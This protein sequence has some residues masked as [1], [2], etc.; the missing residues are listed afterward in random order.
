MRVWARLLLA[1]YLAVLVWL[2]LFKLSLDWGA[3]LREY[4]IR[5]LNLVP[6][7]HASW[8]IRSETVANVLAFVP[9]G[10]LTQVTLKRGSLWWKLLG[11]FLVSV[12]F[13]TT[14]YV[15]A[16][17]V[18]DITDVLTNTMG[19]LLGLLLYR[20]TRRVLP[21]RS[22]DIGVTIGGTVLLIAVVAYRLLFLRFR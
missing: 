16:I 6:F 10:L 7:A 18:T 19:G 1:A 5:E 15:L 3:V 12:V 21:E 4:Q 22:L 20:A 2:V 14:Q 9:F 8:G 13:E 11:I 17:G